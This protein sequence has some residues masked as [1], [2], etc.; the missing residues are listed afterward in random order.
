MHRC[1]YVN[2]SG[3]VLE[4][5][6]DPALLATNLVAVKMRPVRAISRKGS[7]DVRSAVGAARNRA[8]PGRLH[9]RRGQFQRVLPSARGLQDAMEG[10][11]LLQRLATRRGHPR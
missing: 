2:K 3:Y 6:V 5:P 7:N 10:L 4:H 11:A 1:S 9:G 8:L